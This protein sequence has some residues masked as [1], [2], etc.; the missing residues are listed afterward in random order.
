M[1]HYCTTWAHVGLIFL[2]QLT[3][4]LCVEKLQNMQFRYIVHDGIL[5]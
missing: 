3:K 1:C 2:M 4:W 5:F